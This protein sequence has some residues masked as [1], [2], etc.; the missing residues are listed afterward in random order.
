LTVLF[1]QPTGSINDQVAVRAWLLGYSA[2]LQRVLHQVAVAG[3]NYFASASLGT[4]L[5]LDEAEDV[6]PFSM[7]KNKKFNF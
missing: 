1:L 6:S 4:K 5:Q 2:E 3:W 7:K